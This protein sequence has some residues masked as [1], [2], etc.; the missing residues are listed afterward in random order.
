[1]LKKKIIEDLYSAM[2]NRDKTRVSTLRLLKSNIEYEE[3]DK[4]EAL[5]DEDIIR[6]MFMSVRQRKESI[7]LYKKGSRQDLVEKEELELS[8]IS[9]YLPE[10]MEI[11]QIKDVVVKVMSELKISGIA[12][13]GKLMGVV[14]TRLKGKA[15]GSLVNSVVGDLLSGKENQ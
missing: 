9:E 15:E 4:K 13:K 14:M 11:D 3:I 12:D 5:S 6:L 1:M 2:R 8:I 7:T 10:Q